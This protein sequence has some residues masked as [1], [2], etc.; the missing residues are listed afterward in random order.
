[1]LNGDRRDHPF[2]DQVGLSRA[3]SD[4]FRIK[5]SLSCFSLSS[6]MCPEGLKL[7]PRWR[8]T[9][10]IFSFEKFLS[11]SNERIWR[12]VDRRSRRFKCWVAFEA[13]PTERVFRPSDMRQRVLSATWIFFP[14][15]R[16]LDSIHRYSSFIGMEL[17]LQRKWF[18]VWSMVRVWYLKLTWS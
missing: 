6:I 4:D 15:P 13:W 17:K 5:D 9:Q 14:S 11:D 2:S 10:R 18:L 1:M 3:T 7:M 16:Q 8:E 12:E